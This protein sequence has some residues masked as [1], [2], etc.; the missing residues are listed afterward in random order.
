MAN[1]KFNEQMQ[2]FEAKLSA[3][4][5]QC[6][7]A[8]KNCI[9]A[10]TNLKSLQERQAQLIDDCEK[11]AGCPIDRVPEYLANEAAEIEKIMMRLDDLDLSGDITP[12]AL[13]AINDIV[14][15]FSV[16]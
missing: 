4:Q 11:M 13:Q 7:E 9:V 10:E 5:A 6:S 16:A 14:A 1:S 12:E 2:A 3:L 15:E 8:E